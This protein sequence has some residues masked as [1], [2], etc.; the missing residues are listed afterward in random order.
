MTMEEILELQRNHNDQMLEQKLKQARYEN[1]QRTLN[2][3]IDLIAMQMK[4]NTLVLMYSA[5]SVRELRK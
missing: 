2:A 3:G 1:R 4:I 5:L